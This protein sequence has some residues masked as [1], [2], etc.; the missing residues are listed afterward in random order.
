MPTTNQPLSFMAELK[1]MRDETFLFSPSIFVLYC[2]KK[3]RKVNW[4][5]IF[6][7]KV[8]VKTA[9]CGKN[10]NTIKFSDLSFHFQPFFLS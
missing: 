5:N 1:C 6:L 3:I 2:C 7:A 4:K 10:F 8:T 9:N